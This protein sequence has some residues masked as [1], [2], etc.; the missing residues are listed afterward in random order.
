M[1]AER[2]TSD[3]PIEQFRPGIDV[4]SE[5]IEMFQDAVELATGATDNDRKFELFKKWLPLKLD[6]QTRMAYRSCTKVVWAE[7]MV[8]LSG[9]IRDPQTR[10]KWRAGEVCTSWDGQESLNGYVSRVERLVNEQVDN[11]AAKDYFNAFRRGLPQEYRDAIDLGIREECQET[12]SEARK[13]AERL[14]LVMSGKQEG[15]RVSF[16]GASMQ[17]DRLSS[18]EQAIRDLTISVNCN[19]DA[20]SD[21]GFRLRSLEEFCQGLGY[22]PPRSRQGCDYVDNRQP[23]DRQHDGGY[24]DNSPTGYGRS[25]SCGHEQDDRNHTQ[26]GIGSS[27]P[28]MAEIRERLADLQN[29]IDDSAFAND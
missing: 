8:E 4:F 27:K 22:C 13:I 18:L 24:S 10:C 17:D 20:M 14:F 29:M 21:L 1:A 5:W 12:L 19:T 6:D 15:K 25:H 11:P 26:N 2:A 23:D 7:L 28:N 9:L 3:I 16:T